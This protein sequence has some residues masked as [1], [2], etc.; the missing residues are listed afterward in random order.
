MSD[1][2]KFMQSESVRNRLSELMGERVPQFVTSVL[3]AVNNNPKLKEAEP[4]S[5][6]GAAV[7]AALLDM[8][9][10]HNLGYAFI[11]PYQGKNGVVEAQF[12]V[13]YKGLI[14]LAHR[15]GM[16]KRINA[17]DVREGEIK[18]RDRLSGEI[19]FTWHND[20]EREKHPIIGYASYF[21]LTNGFSST[22]YLTIDEVKKHAQE[23][24]MS[25]RKG[26]GIWKDKFDQMALKTVLKLNLSKNAPLSIQLRRAI[27]FDQAV[28]YDGESYV[29]VDNQVEVDEKKRAIAD[30]LDGLFNENENV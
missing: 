8:P 2:V 6:Y 18:E 28:T 25:Y 1:I 5:V 27:E 30:K 16:F 13:G 10:N 19:K 29:Y 20:S 17:T 22:Y 24:S 21:E 3:Q 11:V 12:Q 14:Q 9:I 7:T 15:T 4:Q 26:A 23:Y